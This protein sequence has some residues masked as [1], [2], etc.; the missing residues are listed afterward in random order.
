MGTYSYRLYFYSKK[1]VMEESADDIEGRVCRLGF[2]MLKIAGLNPKQN[3]ANLLISLLMLLPPIACVAISCEQLFFGK[4]DLDSFV[5]N[6]EAFI[7]F[8]EVQKMVHY[9]VHGNILHR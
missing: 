8:L 2:N 1:E 3:K 4:K 9:Y 6:A 5:K 7:V